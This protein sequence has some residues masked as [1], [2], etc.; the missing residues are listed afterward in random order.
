[1]YNP[2]QFANFLFF[3]SLSR[4]YGFISN[5]NSIGRQF[6]ILTATPNEQVTKYL[7][8]LGVNIGWI[9]P[10]TADSAAIDQTHEVPALAPV[11]LEVYSVEDMKDGLLT[12]A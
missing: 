3:M 10:G 4:H 1:Y 2:K 7:Q 11:Y 9:Q 8:G 6:C 5:S 12:L